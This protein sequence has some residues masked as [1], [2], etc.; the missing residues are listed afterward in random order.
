MMMLLLL[1]LLAGDRLAQVHL[2]G[3][4]REQD[5]EEERQDEHPDT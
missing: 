5:E 1:P 4:G 2:P 3:G